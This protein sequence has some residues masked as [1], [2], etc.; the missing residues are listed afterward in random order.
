MAELG[1][2]FQAGFAD[3]GSELSEAGGGHADRGTG[4][5]EAGVDCAGM[6]P[7]GSGD[8]ANVQFVLLKVACKAIFLGAMEFRV[9]L[10]E[11][12]DGIFGEALELDLI[13]NFLALGFRKIGEENFTDGGAVKRNGGANARVDA[14]RFGRIELFD[15]DR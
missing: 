2:D 5:A 3:Q 14:K 8:A 10:L 11:V 6:I 7:D 1:G 13:E 12:A 4:D 9:Q 15:V